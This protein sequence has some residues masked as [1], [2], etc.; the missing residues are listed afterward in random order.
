[1]PN[2]AHDL[3]GD[4][5]LERSRHPR[6][7][8]VIVDADTIGTGHNP[9]CG[10]HMTVQVR[11][12]AD[13][14]VR[15]AAFQAQGCAISIASADLM[16]DLVCQHRPARCR[17]LATRFEQALL[18]ADWPDDLALLRPLAGVREYP[19]RLKCAMLPWRALATAFGDKA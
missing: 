3:Y 18:G 6:H 1:M 11:L 4:T 19:A 16:A 5:V 14:A 15:Q 12:D 17:D 13:G 10:D 8:Q 7:R 9:L 2:D